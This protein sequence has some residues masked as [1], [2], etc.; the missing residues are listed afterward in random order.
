MEALYSISYLS[1]RLRA[2]PR[3]KACRRRLRAA[4]VELF[5]LLIDRRGGD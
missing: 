1:S 4:A 3:T 2:H 5:V